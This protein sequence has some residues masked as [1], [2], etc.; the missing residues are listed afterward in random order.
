MLAMEDRLC[1]VLVPKVQSLCP[2]L[3]T[4]S[5]GS[6]GSGISPKRLLS[7][8]KEIGLERPETRLLAPPAL[9]ESCHLDGTQMSL[10]PSRAIPSK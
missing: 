10:E 8:W 3:S 9:V 7:H 2:V 4:G 5:S 6:V 1:P